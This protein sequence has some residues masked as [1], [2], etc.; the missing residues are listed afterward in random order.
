MK[1]FCVWVQDT[2]SNFRAHIAIFS[3]LLV[4]LCVIFFSNSAR[5]GQQSFVVSSFN[6]QWNGENHENSLRYIKESKA[7]ILVLQE[8][9]EALRSEINE[10]RSTFPHQ[11]G[12]GHSHVMVLSKHEL[13]FVSYLPWPGKFQNRAMH[14]KCN[15]NG[16]CINIIGIHLQVTRTWNEI[17]IRDQQIAT[18][19]ASVSK[20]TDPV[21]VVGDFNASV[22]SSVLRRIQHKTGLQSNTSLCKYLGTWPA[23]SGLL[24]IQLDHCLVKAPLAVTDMALGPR[25]DSDHKPVTADISWINS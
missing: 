19:I 17:G 9:T 16:R 2:L 1:D 6:I 3:L 24:A 7:D 21:A 11:L 12:S 8:V 20:L 5:T 22:G 25:L 14:V 23:N 13:E 4:L 10:Y 15:I 18:L